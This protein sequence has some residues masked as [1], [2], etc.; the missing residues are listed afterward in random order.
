MNL[1]VYNDVNMKLACEF[2]VKHLI[3]R[4]HKLLDLVKVDLLS[5]GTLLQ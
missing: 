4:V 1:F 2:I 3:K 5:N